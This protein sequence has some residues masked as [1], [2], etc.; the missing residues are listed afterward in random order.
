M[1]KIAVSALAVA[2]SM[3]G[4]N[5]AQAEQPLS[6]FAGFEYALDGNMPN[7]RDMIMEWIE[8]EAPMVSSAILSVQQPLGP[9]SDFGFNIDPDGESNMRL[10]I[11][12]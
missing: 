5:S 4:L 8:G 6:S 10:K 9:K 11:Q 1:N 7:P 12:F 2:I 3:A